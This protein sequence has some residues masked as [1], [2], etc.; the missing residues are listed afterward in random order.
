VAA[1]L[2]TDPDLEVRVV[3]GRLLELSI[4]V[5]DEKVIDTN[6]LFYPRPSKIVQ[7]TREL[8]ARQAR[9]G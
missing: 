3:K 2:R 9:H 1:A 5:D 7:R 6:R 8:L 4:A